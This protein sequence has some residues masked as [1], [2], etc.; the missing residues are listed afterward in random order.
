MYTEF[1]S[2]CLMKYTEDEMRVVT[3][4]KC[5]GRGFYYADDV[6]GRIRK[7]TCP[8]C[9]EDGYIVHLTTALSLSRYRINNG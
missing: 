7:R 6:M 9:N 4:Y 3:C 5:G 8:I 1:D 2:K